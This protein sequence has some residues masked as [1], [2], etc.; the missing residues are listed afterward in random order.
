MTRDDLLARLALDTAALAAWTDLIRLDTQANRPAL[1]KDQARTAG[2]RNHLVK[3]GTRPA[4]WPHL[5]DAA[6][7]GV[8]SWHVPPNPGDNR[9]RGIV[10]IRPAA[11][12]PVEA[13][14]LPVPPAPVPYVPMDSGDEDIVDDGEE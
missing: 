7:D 4:L 2:K 11:D 1:T 12:S 13:A 3:I 8:C 5:V 10:L 14:K 9:L 6:R